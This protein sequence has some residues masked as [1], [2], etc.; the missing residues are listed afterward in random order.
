MTAEWNTILDQGWV[1]SYLK[2]VSE[3]Q[4]PPLILLH[5]FTGNEHSVKPLVYGIDPNRWLIS[6][7]GP[8]S[9]NGNGYSWALE[10]SR[11]LNDFQ[12]SANSFFIQWQRVRS[13][14]EIHSEMVDLLGFSQGAAF[15]SVLLLLFPQLVRRVGLLSGFVPKWDDRFKAPSLKGHQMIISHG[16]QDEIIPFEMAQH[17]S[18]VLS[19]LG[20]DVTFCQSETRHKI[21]AQCNAQVMTFFD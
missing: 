14:L 7:R 1:I 12:S 15:A 3:P 2:P 20:A 13:L 18:Q 10:K 5:G 21:G 4:F 8:L 19:S 9:A 6:F 11:S 17:S 16:T